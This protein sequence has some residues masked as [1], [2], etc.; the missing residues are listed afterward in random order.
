MASNI[1]R[2]FKFHDGTIATGN[3]EEMSVNNFNEIMQVEMKTDGTAT[4]IF[5]GMG[6]LG[7]WRPLLGTQMTNPLVILTQTTDMTTFYQFEIAGIN[8]IRMRVTATST[9]PLYIYG[10]ILG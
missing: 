8:K 4:V 3:G 1:L 7:V 2:N 9:D 5:E 10:K 6:E